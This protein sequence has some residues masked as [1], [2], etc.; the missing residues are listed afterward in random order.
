MRRL[1]SAVKE[2]DPDFRLLHSESPVARRSSPSPS[3]RRSSQSRSKR[4]EEAWRLEILLDRPG[5]SDS[6]FLHKGTM[7]DYRYS[8]RRVTRWLATGNAVAESGGGARAAGLRK[9]LVAPATSTEMEESMVTNRTTRAI[10]Y[11][12]WFRQSYSQWRIRINWS[13]NRRL[14][15]PRQDATRHEADYA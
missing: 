6:I 13:S 11:M 15:N 3:R 14:A 8:I 1:S 5:V 9:C 12:L 2:R 4:P 7:L 10:A